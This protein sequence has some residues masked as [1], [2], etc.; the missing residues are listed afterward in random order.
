MCV[1]Q[2]R[3]GRGGEEKNSQPLPIM[4]C[5]ICTKLA[6]LEKIANNKTAQTKALPSLPLLY[7]SV[8]FVCYI[9]KTFRMLIQ[10]TDH[11]LK[12]KNILLPPKLCIWP[13]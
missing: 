8:A 6:D 10:Q 4:S 9:Y 13:F 5:N 11:M 12:R 7:S 3:S 2:S 1:S